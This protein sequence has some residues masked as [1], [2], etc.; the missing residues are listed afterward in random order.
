[1]TMLTPIHVENPGPLLGSNRP[2]CKHL[3]DKKLLKSIAAQWICSYSGDPN[4]LL[5]SSCRTRAS[6]PFHITMMMVHA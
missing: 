6:I 4:W 5:S 2:V 3:T 1:M